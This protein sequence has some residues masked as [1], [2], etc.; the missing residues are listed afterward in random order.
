MPTFSSLI[1]KSGVDVEF[2]RGVQLFGGL[3]NLG[4]SKNRGTTKWMIYNGNPYEQMDDLGVPPFSKTPI[5]E[6]LLPP[7]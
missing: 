4:V 2:H 3:F 6:S 5:Y 1:W 7:T